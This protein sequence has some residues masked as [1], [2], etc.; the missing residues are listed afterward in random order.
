VSE[1]PITGQERTDSGVVDR[2]SVILVD[3][4]RL[5][6]DS[7]LVD[8]SDGWPFV[9]LLIFVFVLFFFIRIVTFTITSSLLLL[10][11]AITRLGLLA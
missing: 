10:L 11:L 3:R 8:R 7:R 2:L 5:A 4:K 1:E 9:Y 6:R